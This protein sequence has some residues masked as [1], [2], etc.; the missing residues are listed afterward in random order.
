MECLDEGLLT[1]EELGIDSMPVF[2]PENFDI[3]EDSRRNAETGVQLI[4]AI[5]AKKGILDLSEGA[6]K[7]A[8]RA[9]RE[10]GKSM[11]DKFIYN[12]NARKGWSVPNQYWTPGVLSPMPVSGKYYMVYSNDFL[13][14]RELGRQNSVRMIQELIMD[15]AGFC[16]FHRTWAEEMIPEIIESLFGLK[17]KFIANIAITAS[18]INSRNSSI[19]W[20]SERNIDFLITFLKRKRD[21]DGSDDG[22]LLEWIRRFDEDKNEAALDFWYEIHKGIHESLREF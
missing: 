5:L 7:F 17:E 18:R 11:L 6:R 10:K 20:E 1:Q 2:S 13:P 22:E 14:P 16:R 15:N 19:F 12:A 3:V 9:S 21:I 4:E 8:R